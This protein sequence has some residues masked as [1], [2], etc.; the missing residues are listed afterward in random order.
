MRANFGF[1]AP[2]SDNDQGKN[3][4]L[5]AIGTKPLP[6]RS[7]TSGSDSK[8]RG[9]NPTART[10]HVSASFSL[11]GYLLTCLRQHPAVECLLGRDFQGTPPRSDWWRGFLQGRWPSRIRARPDQD[12]LAGWGGRILT[13]A[14]Q[15]LNSLDSQPRRRDSNLCIWDSDPLHS[16]SRKRGF[17]AVRWSPETFTNQACPTTLHRGRKESARRSHDAGSRG[18][19]LLQSKMRSFESCCPRWEVLVIPILECR[20]SSP[21]A[22]AS[23][24]VSNGY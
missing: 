14:F 16:L 4:D 13:S 21:A 7:D 17:D 10:N 19:N 2:V 22:P 15:N 11:L 20:C 24:S 18:M 23:Q 9:S 1:G 6:R 3:S 12:G 8:C 5:K